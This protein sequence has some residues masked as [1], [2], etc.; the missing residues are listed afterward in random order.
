MEEWDEVLVRCREKNRGGGPSRFR[1]R[2]TCNGNIMLCTCLSNHVYPESQ[3]PIYVDGLSLL[4]SLTY[5]C[6]PMII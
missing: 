4:S 1:A 2:H 6:F 5:F 3:M